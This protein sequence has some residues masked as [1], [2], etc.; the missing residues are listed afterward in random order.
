MP[1]KLQTII[2]G[3]MK[4]EGN[5]AVIEPLGTSLS[6]IHKRA[7]DHLVYSLRLLALPIPS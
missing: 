4:N 3:G 2:F 6:D 1:P 7:L 5:T